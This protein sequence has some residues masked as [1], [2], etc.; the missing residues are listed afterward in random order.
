MLDKISYINS[1]LYYFS[2]IS[3]G[4]YIYI[5]KWTELRVMVLKY[6]IMLYDIESME[7]DSFVE[8]L[9]HREGTPQ[10]ILPPQ[11]VVKVNFDCSKD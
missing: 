10:W 3:S 6:Q 1:N 11:G 2:K 9:P 8:P 7:V 5:Y 4:I